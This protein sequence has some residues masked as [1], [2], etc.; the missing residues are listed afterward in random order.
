MKKKPML[1][2]FWDHLV[3]LEAGQVTAAVLGEEASGA[4]L[5]VSR[6][7]L[8]DDLR[9]LNDLHPEVAAQLTLLT[10]QA[11]SDADQPMLLTDA[12]KAALSSHP[13][14]LEGLVEER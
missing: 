10:S 11:W 5:Q 12:V 7:L 4:A 3:V 8:G 9:V 13:L 1:F 6:A 2:L 14:L